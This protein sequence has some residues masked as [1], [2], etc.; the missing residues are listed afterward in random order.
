MSRYTTFRVHGRLS[1]KLREHLQLSIFG[2]LVDADSM[3]MQSMQIHQAEL[4]EQI[5]D[6]FVIP[7]ETVNF[8]DTEY[9]LTQAVKNPKRAIVYMPTTPVAIPDTTQ[10]DIIQSQVDELAKQGSQV[11]KDPGELMDYLSGLT[12]GKSEDEE[13]HGTD[14]GLIESGGEV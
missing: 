11:L 13:D 14:A 10:R 5:K 6:L 12:L 1:P 7:Q 3:D 9:L 8:Q 2:K 4:E